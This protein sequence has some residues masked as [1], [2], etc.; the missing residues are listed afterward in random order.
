MHRQGD[1][2]RADPV[3]GI[4]LR[5]HAARCQQQ[6]GSVGV[7]GSVSSLRQQRIRA[8]VA[9]LSGDRH[10][11]ILRHKRSRHGT[12]MARHQTIPER[13]VLQL[14]EQAAVNRIR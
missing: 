5:H 6:A 3:R 14:A 12:R 8:R 4:Q 11:K 1:A 7:C 2:A 13:N 9:R 10:T